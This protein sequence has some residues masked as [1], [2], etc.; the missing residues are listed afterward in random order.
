LK[1][2]VTPT[3]YIKSRVEQKMGKW[4]QKGENESPKDY[5]IRVSEKNKTDKR[6]REGVLEKTAGQQLPWD[7]SSIIGDFVFNY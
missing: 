3:V 4:L 6:V 5:E 1:I 2:N 7:Q